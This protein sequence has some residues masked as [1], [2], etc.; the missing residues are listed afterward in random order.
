MNNEIFANRV[1]ALANPNAQLDPLTLI[2][3]IQTVVAIIKALKACGYLEK[4]LPKVI[5]KPNW[6]QRFRMK[7][8]VNDHIANAK[9]AR[10]IA[11]ALPVAASE[12]NEIQVAFLY[13]E[14][15]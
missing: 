13:A 11:D 8:I 9:L 3:I 5:S 4:D 12:L 15:S 14:P 2:A 1:Y 6:L 7:R 10:N